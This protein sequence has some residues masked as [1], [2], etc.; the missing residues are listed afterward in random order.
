MVGTLLNRRA[1]R[2]YPMAGLVVLAV[3]LMVLANGQAV[4][5]QSLVDWTRASS[6][7]YPELTLTPGGITVVGDYKCAAWPS[8]SPQP[9]M[10]HGVRYL[11]Y[12]ICLTRTASSATVQMHFDQDSLLPP[13]RIL[14]KLTWETSGGTA[15]VTDNQSSS[16]STGTSTNYRGLDLL[17]SVSPTDSTDLG[18]ATKYVSFNSPVARHSSATGTSVVCQAETYSFY[19]DTLQRNIYRTSED[20]ACLSLA[21]FT[22]LS[23]GTLSTI[24]LTGFETG[25]SSS[26]R[27]QDTDTPEALAATRDSSNTVATFR[28]EYP[29][30]QV[31]GYEIQ[32]QKA[33]VISAGD[34]TSI[35]YGDTSILRLDVD[36]FQGADAFID[37]GVERG[38]TYRYRVRAANTARSEWT[39]WSGYALT[40]GEQ[41]LYLDAPANF[42]V[43]RDRSNASV[44]MNWTAPAGQFDGFALQRQEMVNVES[45]TIFANTITLSD[46]LS[47]STLTYT[48]S[49]IAP[50]RTY[51]YRVAATQD[52][53]VGDYSEWARVTPFDS[54]LGTAPANLRFVD[55]DTAR[56]L[57]YRREFWMRWDDIDG[58]DD[59]EVDVLAYN[60][61]AG[62]R[63]METLLLSDPTVFRTAYGRVELRVRGRKNDDVLC[64][65][66][67][68]TVEADEICYTDW[69]GWYRVQFTPKVQRAGGPT[70][71]PD[72]SIEE[73]RADVDA[74]LDS[75][76]DQSG[77]DVDPSLA[78]QFAVLVGTAVLAIASVVAGWKRGMR[79]LGVGMAF[80]VTVVSLYVAQQLLGIP[81]AWAIGAQTLIAIPGIIAFARQLGAFR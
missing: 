28:W 3:G 36:K 8:G 6:G 26:Y 44:T 78:V 19:S 75:T 69:T 40:A 22:S 60:A 74:L 63:S 32:R 15:I 79:P 61:A 27:V 59:Y 25:L 33:V 53:V 30:K 43:L 21:D 54:S 4:R 2:F 23:A 62:Q 71:I 35:Q 1:M 57:D 65:D 45:S 10:I 13:R 38:A 67:D 11:F 16:S 34:S 70:P 9:V 41:A 49:S 12:G 39:E 7:S 76:L 31:G 80:S 17:T 72:A 68:G 51:E 24:I 20:Y 52:D 64:G 66:G 55:D 5:A 81:E 37:S 77:V 29:N 58:A 47:S 50:G 46:S 56:L 18:F 73:F 48:D 42:E 14:H